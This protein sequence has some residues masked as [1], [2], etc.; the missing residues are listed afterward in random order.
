MPSVRKFERSA[1]TLACPPLALYIHVPWCVKKCPY[2]DFNSHQAPE[3]LLPEESYVQALVGDLEHDLAFVADRNLQ[4]IFIGGGTPSLFSPRVIGDL[5]RQIAARIDCAPDMEVTLEANPGTIE[6]GRF[7]GYRE[8]GINR[9]SL[10]V[11][12]F[13]A[14]HLKR[15]GRIHSPDDVYRAVVELGG[16]GISNFNLD[17]MY[18]LPEQSLGQAVSDVSTAI[19]LGPAHLSHYQLTL[20]PGTVFHHRPPAAMPDPEV[21]WEMQTASQALLEQGGFEQYEVSAY[22]SRESRCRHNLNYWQFGDYLGIGAGAHGKL[23]D[24]AT[25]RIFR[26]TRHKQPRAYLNTIA[27]AERLEEVRTVSPDDLPFE[28]MLN[29]LRLRE[30]FSMEVFEARTGL[31]GPILLQ[32]LRIAESRGLLDFSQAGYWLPSELGWR[33]LNDLQELFLA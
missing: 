14:G 10:G 20:E 17:L 13:D 6:H 30:G 18:A 9:V 26:T 7:A 19:D 16:A 15:L 33:F 5:L 24:V 4:S 31:A 11:Q 2:C 27:A 12:S 3:G 25:G 29:A 8:A 28:F 32:T 21:A 22:A 23:T 1:M